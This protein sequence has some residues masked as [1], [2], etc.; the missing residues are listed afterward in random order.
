MVEIKFNPENRHLHARLELAG[1]NDPITVEITDYEFEE[2]DGTTKLIVKQAK[3]DREWIELLIND[4]L[5]GK[6]INL[7]SDKV[8]L[9]R[10]ILQA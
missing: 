4:I 6:P 8:K 7:P 5:I 3:V 10:G 1:E 9:I 2:S